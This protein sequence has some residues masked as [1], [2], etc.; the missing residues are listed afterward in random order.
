MKSL[1][2]TESIIMY[3]LLIIISMIC[4]FIAQS[5]R[6]DKNITKIFEIFLWSIAFIILFLPLALRG[7]GV[8]HDA[9]IEIY[10]KAEILGNNYWNYYEWTPE[11]FYALI[12]VISANIFKNMQYVYIISA[13]IS[14]FFSFKAF[15]RMRKKVNVIIVLWS[16]LTSY[17]FYNYGLVRISIAVGLITYAYKYI[18]ERKRKKYYFMCIIATMFHYSAIIM[19]PMYNLL[20]HDKKNKTRNLKIKQVI[21]IITFF[22][23]ILYVL[24]I[25]VNSIPWLAR[26]K[27][28]FLMKPSF[29]VLN[30][31]A[32]KYP[33][34]LI[35]L[36]FS[37]TIGKKMEKGNLYLDML[38]IMVIIT[39]ISIVIPLHRFT[40]YLYPATYYL[41]A[42]IP[43][44]FN[45]NRSLKFIYYIFILLLGIMWAYISVFK[46]SLWEPYLIPYYYVTNL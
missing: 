34:I 9:Y 26:Y 36:L 24:P 40:Y 12:N 25:L 39:I 17:Y 16:Y 22:A 46:S 35:C 15:F 5:I 38:R 42:F 28:Y 2:N 10:K 20:L 37:K 21:F 13:F 27:G 30:N 4:I 41:Y 31:I 45:K 11:P 23:A 1:S 7:Y 29:N 14:L 44:L 6:K 32:N 8:D 18:E 3:I 43:S 19:L 33:L